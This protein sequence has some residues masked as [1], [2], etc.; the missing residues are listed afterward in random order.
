M[1][2]ILVNKRFENCY[3]NWR[4]EKKTRGLGSQKKKTKVKAKLIIIR[5]VMKSSQTVV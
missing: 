3:K 5:L 2:Y 1:S 4:N